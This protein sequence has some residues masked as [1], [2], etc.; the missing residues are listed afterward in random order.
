MI[1]RNQ[2]SGSILVISWFWYF[3]W[4]VSNYIDSFLM[5]PI[6]DL[7]H[8][9]IW[10]LPIGTQHPQY[11]YTVRPSTENAG[12]TSLLH[13]SAAD[14]TNQHACAWTWQIEKSSQSKDGPQ[15]QQGRHGA[16]DLQQNSQ[17]MQQTPIFPEHPRQ[18]Q[19]LRQP[20]FIQ[21]R[22]QH[23]TTLS[24]LTAPWLHV[25]I[26]M[27]WFSNDPQYFGTLN[28]IG[29]LSLLHCMFRRSCFPNAHS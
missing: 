23:K 11:G 21:Q 10:I 5:R 7:S 4:F 18:E 22:A 24:A 13:G 3:W 19:S 9:L 27:K 1:N 25:H 29:S 15:Q 17:L 28:Y 8:R 16:P 6:C 12:G 14:N 26:G 2:N 20:Q